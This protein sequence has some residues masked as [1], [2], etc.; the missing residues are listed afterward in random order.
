MLIDRLNRLY[1]TMLAQGLDALAINPGPS[2]VYLTGLH[3]HLSERPTLLLLAPPKSPVLILPELE[4]V[5]A[6]QCSLPLHLFPFGDTPATWQAVFD[7]AVKS[8]G[9]GSL[10]IGVEPTRL[11]VL[12][13]R[14]L[15][16]A[17]PKAAFISAE[18]A[19]A[20]LRMQKD[21]AELAAMH[22]AAEIA[23]QGLQAVL[24]L[25]KPGISEAE[26]ASELVLQLL[27][28]GSQG[29]LPFQPIV[30]FGPNTAD[31]HAVPT[32][33]RLAVGDMVLFDWGAAYD[34]YCSD[35]T[36]TFAMGKIDPEMQKIYS[37][38]QQANAA[39]R[40][41]GKPGL[42]AGDIDRAAR[43]VINESGYG[44]RFTHRTGHG[45][46]MEAH[47]QPYMF[48][49]N[50]LVLAEGMTF[51]VEPG[52]YLPGRGGVRIEDDV[53]ITADGSDSLTDYPRDLVILE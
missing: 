20:G 17:A 45:L 44:A 26:L 30:S 7:E 28:A 35:I 6:Q 27:R 2:M 5:K 16:A 13:L 22:R 11:R 34:G 49:E 9:V 14:F 23:Q 37:I 33:R 41:A 42:L 53:F 40:A 48:G 38:V 1:Q 47:E 46:G 32:E 52:I 18:A 19:L 25:V 8:I 31:P 15:E 51:T 21:A 12:E 3:F 36:R 24:P 43:T 10:K 50:T 29:E 39:G 4:M